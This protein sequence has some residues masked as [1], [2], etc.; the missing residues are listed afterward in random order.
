M[1]LST[2]SRTVCGAPALRPTDVTG[3][4]GTADTATAGLHEDA[5]DT[6]VGRE[7]G[8]TICGERDWSKKKKEIKIL[9]EIRGNAI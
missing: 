6:T 2:T 8:G 9:V 4:T 3:D 5:E 1:R 7:V